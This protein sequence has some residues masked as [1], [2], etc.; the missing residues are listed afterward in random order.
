MDHLA[1]LQLDHRSV[2]TELAQ[3]LNQM[4]FVSRNEMNEEIH[5]LRTILP[6]ETQEMIA[7]KISKLDMEL[8]MLSHKPSYEKAMRFSSRYVHSVEFKLRFLRAEVFDPKSAAVRLEKYLSYTM[9]H[10]G[11]EALK[12][13]INLNDLDKE[14]HD[15]L[16]AGNFQILPCRDRSGRRIAMRMGAI[17]SWSSTFRRV[18]FVATM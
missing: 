8:N 6:D 1:A 5:G 12:R 11:E 16:K 15:I 18:R 2:E 3:E 14:E 7:S 17:G 9:E 13:P 4:S 10:F